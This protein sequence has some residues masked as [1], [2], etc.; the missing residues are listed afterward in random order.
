MRKYA[1]EQGIAEEEALK[2]GME[3]KSLEIRLIDSKATTGEKAIHFS[4]IDLT[5]FLP[6]PIDLFSSF[7]KRAVESPDQSS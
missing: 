2:K 6:L 4:V 5:P 3:E 1:A 7:L